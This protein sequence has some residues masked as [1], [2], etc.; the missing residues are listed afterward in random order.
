MPPL[1]WLELCGFRE[2]PPTVQL[3]REPKVQ[4]AYEAYKASLH[5]SVGED[6]VSRLAKLKE[7][8]YGNHINLAKECF[9]ARNNFPYWCETDIRHLVV[10]A[11]EERQ[12]HEIDSALGN[13]LGE[14]N[15]VLFSNFEWNK[16]VSDVPHFH[17][18]L[19]DPNIASMLA[20]VNL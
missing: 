20:V 5:G 12:F 18:F 1:T 14:D 7:Q 8:D 13:L 11:K 15:F 19:K 4:L 17:L 6:I 2:C 16:S 9:V 10:W 3:T